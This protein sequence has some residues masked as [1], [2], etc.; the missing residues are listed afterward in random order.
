MAELSRGIR[1]RQLTAFALA[2]VCAAL[3]ALIDSSL[4]ILGLIATQLFL[5]LGWRL[6]SV[7]QKTSAKSKAKPEW[8]VFIGLWCL[9]YA[10][11]ALFLYWPLESLRYSGALISALWLS[12]AV[13]LLILIYWRHWPWLALAEQ[14]SDRVSKWLA[15]DSAPQAYSL[16]PG[17]FTTLLWFTVMALGLSFGIGDF[18]PETLF[19]PILLLHFVISA[20][21]HWR[22]HAIEITSVRK[23][24]DDLL[25][26][27]A[28]NLINEKPAIAE[29]V[30]L[31]AAARR[32]QVDAALLAIQNGADVNALPDASDIDQR[33]LPMLAA[34]LSDQRLLRE[35]IARGVDINKAHQ[36]LTALLTATRDSWHGRPE[37]VMMLLANG[38]DTRIADN[39]GY[40][41]LHHAARS[42]DPAVAALLLDAGASHEAITNE[43]FNALGVACIA[44][45]WRLAKFLMERGSKSEPPNGQ[46]ALIA[47]TMGED[48]PA[49][50]QLLLRHK[51]RVDARGIHQNTALLQACSLGNTDIAGVLLDAGADRNARNEFQRTPLLEAAIQGSIETLSRLLQAKPDLHAIDAE[52]RNALHLACEH[53]ASPDFVKLLIQ[54]GVAADQVDAQGF[55]AI[56]IAIGKENWPLV[57]ILDPQH[58]IPSTLTDNLFEE[59]QLQPSPRQL[60]REALLQN[61]AADVAGYLRGCDTNSLSSMLLEFAG[62]ADVSRME[63][64]LQHGARADIALEDGDCAFFHLLDRAGHAQPALLYLLDR[65]TSPSGLGGLARYLAVCMKNEYVTR[66]YE[67]FALQLL[68]RGAD[69]FGHP[70]KQDAPLLQSIHLGWNRLTEALL[71]SGV[72]PNQRDARGFSALHL[73]AHLGREKSIKQLLYFGADLNARTADGQSALG[74]ALAAGQHDLSA[75]LEWRS[76]QPPGRKLLNLDLPAAAMT[77]DTQAVSRLIEL[78]LPINAQDMQACTALLR[79]AGGGHESIVRYL[80][81]NGADHRIA[82]R[83]GATALSA[84]ISMRHAQV[85]DILLR[86]GADAEQSLPGGVTPLMLASALGLPD[87]ISH[88][89]SRGAEPNTCDAQGFNALHCAA[90]HGFSSRDKQRVLAMFDMLLFADVEFDSITKSGQTPLHFLLGARAE[91]GASCDEDVL[92]AAMERLLSEGIDLDTQD[93]RGMSALHLAATHGLS[94]IVNRLLREGANRNARDSLGRT[95]HELA[96]VRGFVDVA[97]EFETLRNAQPS[98]AR[99]L[100]DP[101]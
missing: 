31:Y 81:N 95:P 73:A 10:L 53:G 52:A 57:A 64:L 83:T 14:G 71:Q 70:E 33:S 88:L 46:S 94:R 58:E 32:N 90:I 49:G 72:N 7:D 37:A 21:L 11:M 4:A 77:G 98:M 87:I 41:P 82:A 65:G 76:W 60:I 24:T 100:R 18:I 35:L 6:T 78:G 23:A 99:F 20:V 79:A 2:V 51:A 56:D 30:S 68:E 25:P 75:W 16:I 80:L 85:V 89:L 38:A 61:D 34:L 17:L 12:A 39:D 8:I 50:V 1:W 42:S 22:L 48:D 3:P 59:H 45:N 47:A 97:A 62:D 26:T 66:S 101:N 40:T 5:G 36:G 15:L 13:A 69:A 54:S 29:P 63:L 43:G 9:A 86:N 96:L 74:I 28:S 93:Q 91:A 84:A 19:F 55:R 44:N 27:K 67:N 92:I